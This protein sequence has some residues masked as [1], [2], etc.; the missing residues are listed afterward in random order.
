M[1]LPQSMTLRINNLT[2]SF[3]RKI[4]FENINFQLNAGDSLAVTGRN[5][6]GKSTLIKILSGTLIPSSGDLEISEA[7]KTL[8]RDDYRK[9]I[10][11]VSP[12]LFFY[13]EFTAAETLR[14]AARIRGT[15]E[16]K[17]DDILNNVGLYS[18][19]NDAVRIY[20]SGMKQRLK[21][22][23]AIIHEPPIL[24]L[25]EPISNLDAEGIKMAEGLVGRYRQ[26]GIII[27]ATNSR[28][29]RSWCKDEL[30]LDNY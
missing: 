22:G 15:D 17:I 28:D 26:N 11:L 3:D 21:F 5:G 18:S 12:Y 16:T 27:V 14:L 10:G 6:S 1:D 20:S 24:M 25:D 7:G 4:V 23:F 9:F 2:K 29:E 30:N 13:E 8:P 19:R